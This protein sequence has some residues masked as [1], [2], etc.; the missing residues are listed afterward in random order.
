MSKH[1]LPEGTARMINELINNCQGYKEDLILRKE[2]EGD[3]K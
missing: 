3:V 2:E 1:D